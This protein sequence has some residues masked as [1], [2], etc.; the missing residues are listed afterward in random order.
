M[1]ALTDGLTSEIASIKKQPVKPIILATQVTITNPGALD[2][3]LTAAITAR[4][5]GAPQKNK[6]PNFSLN[7]K[8]R[9]QHNRLPKRMDFKPMKVVKIS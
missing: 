4:Y 2:H 5:T 7:L 3:I 6:N 8:G 1:A 9:K